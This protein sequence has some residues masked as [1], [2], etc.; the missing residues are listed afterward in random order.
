LDGCH[1]GVPVVGTA[2]PAG[3]AKKNDAGSGPASMVFVEI[4]E[5]RSSRGHRISVV[6]MMAAQ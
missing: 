5:Q 4:S 3:I 2:A 1:V 6:M